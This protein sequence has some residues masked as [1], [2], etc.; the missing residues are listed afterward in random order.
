MVVAIRTEA[1]NRAKEVD[2]RMGNAMLLGDA[3]CAG[4]FI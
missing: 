3:N 4:R 1:T 2:W